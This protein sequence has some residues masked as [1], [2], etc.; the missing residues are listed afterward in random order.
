MVILGPT[1]IGKTHWAR[2]LGEHMYFNHLFNIDLWNPQAKYIIFDDMEIDYIPALKAF[3]GAQ[4]EFTLT[5]KYRK[6]RNIQFGKPM[7]FL[8]NEDF[9]PRKSKLW[10]LWHSN[11]CTFVEVENNF[12]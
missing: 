7:I 3:W 5:D 12:Y 9:D 2:S 11:N 1:R 8:C 10:S 4:Q 6:K